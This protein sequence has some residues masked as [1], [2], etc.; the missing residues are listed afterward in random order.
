[1]FIH[2]PTIDHTI[3]T[4]LCIWSRECKNSLKSAQRN[5]HAYEYIKLFVWM[6]MK[7]FIA[8]PVNSILVNLRFKMLKYKENNKKIC[9]TFDH[10]FKN[11]PLYIM[12]KA[13]LERYYFVLYD[14]ALTSK[15]SKMVL[16]AFCDKIFISQAYI[17]WKYEYNYTLQS[18]CHRQ[19]EI[20]VERVERLYI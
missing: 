15:M 7:S 9:N 20:W 8:K 10:D 19:G 6:N 2:I 13:S 14:G 5:T 18:F 12:R 4:Q 1:M 11:I 3:Y 16:N 17:I